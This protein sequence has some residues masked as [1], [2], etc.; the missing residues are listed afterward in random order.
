MRIEYLRCFADF[1]CVSTD[2]LLGLTETRSTNTT[3]QAITNAT[4]LSEDVVS[5]FM[6][7]KEIAEY[8]PSFTADCS[9][10]MTEH[11]FRSLLLHLRDYLKAITAETKYNEICNTYGF[12]SGYADE[13]NKSQKLAKLEIDR[14]AETLDPDVASY[15][16]AINEFADQFDQKATLVRTL[17][18]RDWIT[19]SELCA[20]RANRELT[21]LIEAL[22]EKVQNSHSGNEAKENGND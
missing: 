7:F 13:Y 21:F 3:V 16:R 1:Y 17:F 14:I 10:I 22:Q 19:P 15:L 5:W 11:A 9:T 8:I 4:G 6:E 18:G 12:E 2:Y 20:H